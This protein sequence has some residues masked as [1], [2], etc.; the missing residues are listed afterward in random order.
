ME[1]SMK[2][3]DVAWILVLWCLL[4]LVVGIA[5]CTTSQ[6]HSNSIGTVSYQKNPYTYLSGAVT[7]VFDIENRKGLVVRVQPT[8]TYSLFTED[9]L[10][11]N[12]PIE[13]LQGKTN[14]M[15]LTYETRAHKTIQDI[16]CH[17][18]VRVEEI[19]HEEISK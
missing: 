19:K 11:C 10:L 12:S 7:E 13:M 14:P 9:V 1:D 2:G 8:A 17:V 3:T 5:H 18:L 16:G 6:K 15:V 4:L